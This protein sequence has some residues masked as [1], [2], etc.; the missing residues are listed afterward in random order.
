MI[1]PKKIPTT[2]GRT[3][4]TV[5]AEI[6]D[7]FLAEAK[8]KGVQILEEVG[9]FY[10]ADTGSA[11]L[12]WA[13]DVSFRAFVFEIPSIAHGA[14]NLRA[15]TGQKTYWQ[16]LEGNQHRRAT[17]ISEALGEREMESFSY[18]KVPLPKRGL[19]DGTG[20]IN[21]AFFLLTTNLGV[22]MLDSVARFPGA[23]I[24]LRE[25]KVGPPSRAYLKLWEA[26]ARIGDYPLPGAR[27]LDLGSCPGGWTW[28]LAKLGCEVLS[29]D[30]APLEPAVEAMPGV[31]FKKGD[32]FKL[33][34]AEATAHFGGK[35]IDW[36][37]SDM[38]CEPA[39]LVTLLTTWIESGVCGRFIISVKFKGEADQA[40]IDALAALPGG[41]LRHLRQNKHELTW[42]KVPHE[43]SVPHP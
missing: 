9:E 37:F 36:I 42:I 18:A 17:L 20:T 13:T 8:R 11:D 33:T 28:A 40:A 15:L 1:I 30:G 38:I 2:S 25:E 23:A 6:R 43:S 10:V 12:V 34:P 22:A 24:P 29:M 19:G 35:P 32:A 3:V 31:T 7:E 16:L 5:P 21:A 4:Y 41:T 27:V 39:R 14:K 26:F